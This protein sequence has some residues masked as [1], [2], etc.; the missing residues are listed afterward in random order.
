[1]EIARPY[2]RQM[3]WTGWHD[4]VHI[5]QRIAP[6]NPHV[7]AQYFYYRSTTLIRYVVGNSAVR[8]NT[9]KYVAYPE[10]HLAEG[11]RSDSRH[12]YVI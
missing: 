7:V 10:L 8:R 1:M 9:S 3:R 12:R 5:A 2:Y 6:K 11:K 4:K